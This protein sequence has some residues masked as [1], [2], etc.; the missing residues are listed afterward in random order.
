MAYR[1]RRRRSN[2]SYSFRG[3]KGWLRRANKRHYRRAKRSVKRTA[4]R[5]YLWAF[6]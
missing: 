2:G 5:A 4:R 1:R 6:S 3:P